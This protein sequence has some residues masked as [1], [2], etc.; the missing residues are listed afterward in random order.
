MPLTVA[1]ARRERRLGQV[2]KQKEERQQQRL[3]NMRAR[4]E[5]TPRRS[6]KSKAA[7]AEQK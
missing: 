4:R 2:K 6:A 3:D 1:C 7:E 5:G